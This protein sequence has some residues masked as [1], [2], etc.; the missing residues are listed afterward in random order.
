MKQVMTFPASSAV[1]R[2]MT[3]TTSA[4]SHEVTQSR[5]PL[6]TQ[7]PS[8]RVATGFGAPARRR[9]AKATAARNLPDSI[10]PSQRDFSSSTNG[11][12]SVGTACARLRSGDWC[13]TQ[14]NQV[15]A[16]AAEINSASSRC[17]A[18]SSGVPRNPAVASASIAA[19]WTPPWST[20]SAPGAIAVEMTAAASG[21][22]SASAPTK[23][24][25][26]LSRA[27]TVSA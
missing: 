26:R 9:C 20:S 7:P 17:A 5:V 3:I 2:A 4:I 10:P 15:E 12:R 27:D 19:R 22:S 8:T 16:S 21:N 11:A 13:W 14:Q 18:R 6:S 1:P 23:S 24:T 25:S